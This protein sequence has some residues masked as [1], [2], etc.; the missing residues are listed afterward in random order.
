LGEVE[1]VAKAGELG[2]SL[3]LAFDDGVHEAR[4]ET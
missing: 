3:L 1:E 2:G 4:I